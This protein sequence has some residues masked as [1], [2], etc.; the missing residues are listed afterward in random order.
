MVEEPERNDDPLDAFERQSSSEPAME[1]HGWAVAG[2]VGEAGLMLHQLDNGWVRVEL[3][4]ISGPEYHRISV[5]ADPKALIEELATI[6][7]V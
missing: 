1:V 7:D 4:W 5:D 2:T 3:Q 6:R